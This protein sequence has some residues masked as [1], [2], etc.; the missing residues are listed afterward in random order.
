MVS[1]CSNNGKNKFLK[2]DEIKGYHS[3]RIL[4]VINS[5][6]NC[7]NFNDKILGFLDQLT[8]SNV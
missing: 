8:Y 5:Q 1:F 3:M 4:F 2:L 7:E 6:E